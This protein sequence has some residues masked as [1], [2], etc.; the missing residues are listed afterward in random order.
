M[1]Y[2]YGS[3]VSPMGCWRI[4]HVTLVDAL[5]FKIIL[6]QKLE[7]MTNASRKKAVYV[8]CE[9]QQ[10]WRVQRGI[11]GSLEPYSRRF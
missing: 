6:L 11:K 4:G 7:N 3:S 2:L 5:Q 8:K 10:Q 9:H 1:H